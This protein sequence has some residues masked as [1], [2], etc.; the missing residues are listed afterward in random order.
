MSY[1]N[2]FSTFQDRERAF[3]VCNRKRNWEQVESI[4]WALETAAIQPFWH[5]L[6]QRK[7]I[8]FKVFSQRK[9]CCCLIQKTV[10]FKTC[11]FGDLF[12]LLKF[13]LICCHW[14]CIIL[15]KKNKR[16]NADQLLNTFYSFQL[17]LSYLEHYSYVIIQIQL[18]GVSQGSTLRAAPAQLATLTF[19]AGLALDSG[20]I[21]APL[22][23]HIFEFFMSKLCHIAKLPEGTFMNVHIETVICFLPIT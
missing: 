22:P 6:T 3:Y 11:F 14:K 19:R 7:L 21:W 15:E 1:C 12:L 20:F 18:V 5:M 17:A 16:R 23:V 4:C 10:L 9:Q 8:I 13:S 2:F